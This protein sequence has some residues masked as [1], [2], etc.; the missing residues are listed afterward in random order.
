MLKTIQTQKPLQ[1]GAQSIVYAVGGASITLLQHE[2]IMRVY[3]GA[4]LLVAILLARVL[5]ISMEKSNGETSTV[6]SDE[7]P[8]KIRAK[9]EPE[10]QR[11]NA[12]ATA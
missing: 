11:G 12:Q 9:K 4:A 3:I 5:I 1:T 6:Y 2:D 10:T 8:E 7:P